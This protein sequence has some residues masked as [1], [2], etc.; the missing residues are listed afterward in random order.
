MRKYVSLSI[1]QLVSDVAV[2]PLHVRELADSIKLTGP[3]S[4]VLVREDTSEVIDGFHRVAAMHEL[5]FSTVECIVTPCDQD[6]FW[7]LR[8]MSA[9]LHKAV[10][11]ARAVDWIDEAFNVSAWKQRYA[12]AFSLFAQAA[13]REAPKEAQEWAETKA[14]KWGLSVRTIQNWLMAKQAMAPELEEELKRPSPARPLA[15]EYYIEVARGLPTRPDLQKQVL[16]KAQQEGLGRQ[17]VREIAKAIRQAAD[18]EEVET[19]L[20]EPVSRTAED[21]AR[22]AKVERILREPTVTP[23]RIERQHELTGLVLE[24]YLRSTAAGT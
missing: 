7:D 23:T 15:P 6:T 4:P 14:Q 16:E 12:S 22:A 10:T 17:G 9:T 5:G 20:A 24:V 18:E 1:D 19:I 11:F 13:S 8:I 2:D 21:L 3:I